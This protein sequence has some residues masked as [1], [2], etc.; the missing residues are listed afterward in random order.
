MMS[1]VIESAANIINFSLIPQVFLLIFEDNLHKKYLFIASDISKNRENIIFQAFTKQHLYKRIQ[2]FGVYLLLFFC[3]TTRNLPKKLKIPS[4]YTLFL[5]Y[6]KALP[7][8][9]L[10]ISIPCPPIY[11]DSIKEATLLYHQSNHPNTLINFSS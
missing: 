1:M 3:F 2:R 4:Y 6:N 7:H 11:Q 8:K 10:P 5:L 9:L